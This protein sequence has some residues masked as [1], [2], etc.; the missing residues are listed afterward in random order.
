M[1]SQLYASWQH[2]AHYRLDTL[3]LC[4]TQAC[5]RGP[6]LSMRIRS[7]ALKPLIHKVVVVVVILYLELE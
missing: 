2:E 5:R 3:L 7:E 6:V 1:L 4:R